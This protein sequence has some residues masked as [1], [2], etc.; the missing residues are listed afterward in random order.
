[1][2]VRSHRGYVK[3][4]STLSWDIVDDMDFMDGMDEILQ[5]IIFYKEGNLKTPWLSVCSVV[6]YNY[7]RG[8]GGS[9][10][11]DELKEHFG[12]LVKYTKKVSNLFC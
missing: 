7:H 3:E 9:R 4:N 6:E 2:I 1:M 11:G 5:G 12:L 8:S 10:R